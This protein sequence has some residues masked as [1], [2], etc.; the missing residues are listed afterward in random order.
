MQIR[1]ATTEDIPAIVKLLKVSLG[2]SLMPKSEAFWYWKHIENPFGVSP[3]L[4]AVEQSEII[5]VRAFMRWQW[6]RAGEVLHAVRA[7]DTATH[8][9]HQG[10]GI[11]KKL[12]LAL[13]NECE[14]AGT[15]FIFNTPNTSS[16][17]GY[18]KMGWTTLGR[19]K[20]YVRP[21]L[22]AKTKAKDFDAQYAISK[23]VKT[24]ELPAI[25]TPNQW[26]TPISFD[27]LNW[28]YIQN[29]NVQ[30]YFFSDHPEKPTYLSVFRLKPSRFG[31]E[32]RLCFSVIVKDNMKRHAEHA[33]EVARAAGA[34]FITS[35]TPL[36]T[37]MAKVS[38]GP[39]VTI[40]SLSALP[41][42]ISFNNW[43][44]ALGDM[45]LF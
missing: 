28:R 17:P 37:L 3:V 16:K 7:V 1:T 39:E 23:M 18:L 45:E 20:I 6:I 38:A 40:R 12:T 24:I 8:P 22:Y 44:P 4:L 36:P 19:M 29:P 21:L 42:I 30:Y 9:N 11:F 33:K 25:V 15:H 35:S 31:T 27:F 43:L 34:R 41:E 10:K 2:E 32:F 26:R 13:V 5:G 14:A